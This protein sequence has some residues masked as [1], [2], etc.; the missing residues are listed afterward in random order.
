L[1][2]QAAQEC[3]AARELRR[4]AADL[5]GYTRVLRRGAIDRQR[6]VERAV[7]QATS[8]A[9]ARNPPGAARPGVLSRRPERQGAA[10]GRQAV[11]RAEYR[12]VAG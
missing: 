11:I 3:A 9:E 2:A 6:E 8:S 4:D 5:L 10:D 1:L 7:A 12:R